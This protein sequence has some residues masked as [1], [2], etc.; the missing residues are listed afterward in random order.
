TQFTLTYSA[1]IWRSQTAGTGNRINVAHDVTSGST[2][3]TSPNNSPAD[4]T[5]MTISGTFTDVPEL[6]TGDLP[7]ITG[8]AGAQNGNLDANK[9]VKSFTVTG[10]SWNPGTDLYIRF[11][12]L[13]NN[14]GVGID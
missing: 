12:R 1:E 11:Q 3:P 9:I 7:L 10:I 2:D 8:T 13:A 5:A 14:H 4:G 6:S